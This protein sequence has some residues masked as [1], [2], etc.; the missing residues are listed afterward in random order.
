MIASV[1]QSVIT[2]FKVE[3]YDWGV[4]CLDNLLGEI[5]GIVCESWNILELSLMQ[6]IWVIC[7]KLNIFV[8]S[9]SAMAVDIPYKCF[10]MVIILGTFIKKC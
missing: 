5:K 7:E 3:I 9:L 4:L 2:V 10:K 8:Q 6:Y 1:F